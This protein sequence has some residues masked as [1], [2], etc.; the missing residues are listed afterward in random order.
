M[1]LS[2]NPPSISG[3]VFNTNTNNGTW[4]ASLQ[5][6]RATNALP[7]AQYTM[8]IPPDTNNEP[9]N[10]SPGGDG[11]ALI[12]NY[13]G[14]AGNP[15]AATAKITGALADGAAFSQTVPVS[16]TG[17]V[18]IYANLYS[19][20]G[21]LLG[22]VNLD[23]TNTDAVGVSGLTWIHPARSTGLYQKGF[24]NVLLT[25]QILLSLWTNLPENSALT[26][27]TNLS[28]L[29]TINATNGESFAV[30]T[31]A[32]GKVAGTSVSGSITPKTGLLKVTIGSGASKVTG[33]GAILLN[34]T[35]G[36]GNYGG[37]YYLTKTNNAQAIKLVP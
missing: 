16:Q 34:P 10:T 14:T 15:A 29:D 18:P 4:T 12:T 31:T 32:G 24:T 35:N 20:K 6:D 17:L 5:A 22:W 25:N 33:Y 30:T 27:L 37:G 36:G 21:L 2:T 9:P 19:G 1:T 23:L 8:L 26:N 3:S 13:A 11:Y 7:S 28:L